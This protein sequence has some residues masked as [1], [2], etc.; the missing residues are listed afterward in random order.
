MEGMRTKG[1]LKAQIQEHGI[2]EKELSIKRPAKD[3]NVL[4]C[5]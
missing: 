1:I 4:E 2:L 5:Q 3:L